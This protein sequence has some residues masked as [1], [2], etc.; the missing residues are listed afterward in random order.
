MSDSRRRLNWPPGTG[1]WER[2]V[3]IGAPLLVVALLMANSY[4]Y[5]LRVMTEKDWSGGSLATPV[6]VA[7][8][9]LYDAGAVTANSLRAATDVAPLPET[10]SL[11]A[12]QLRV[13]PGSLER[14]T[15]GLPASAKA[16]YY[17]ARLL[18][19]DGTWRRVE[20]RLRGR[21]AWHWGRDKPSLRVKL[22]KA[23]PLNWQRH[24]NFINPEDRAMVAN[25][26]DEYLAREMGLL[27]HETTFVRLFINGAYRGVYHR[28]THE[29]ESLLRLRHRLP[30]PIYEAV[31]LHTRWR[32]EDF[33]VRDEGDLAPGLDPLKQ[34]TDA[35]YL[36]PG[37]ERYAALWR[38]LSFDQYARYLAHMNLV[39]ATHADYFHNQIFYFNPAAG[40]LEPWIS[41]SNGHGMLLL[42]RGLD[43]LTATRQGDAEVPLNELMTPLVDVVLRDPRL[44]HR[45]N[46]H[47]HEALEGPG[48]AKLRRAMLRDLFQR[49]DGD[50]RADRHK[51]A[52]ERDA[53]EP[54]RLI[55]AN[56]QY[57][58][59]KR[60]LM[61]WIGLR[62]GFLRRR[63]DDARVRIWRK[64][65]GAFTV[66]VAGQAAVRFDAARLN[67]DLLAD[68]DLDGRPEAAITKPLLL[69]P[70]LVEATGPVRPSL[71]VFHRYPAHRLV[72]GPERYRFSAPGLDA[73]ALAGAFTNAVTGATVVPRVLRGAA[74]EE[75]TGASIHPWRFPHPA[76]GDLVLGPG[77]VRLD[78]TLD[79]PAG[80]R[81]I[82]R[83]GTR[84]KLGPDVSIRTRG[85]LLMDGTPEQPISVG[86][87]EPDRAWGVIAIQGPSAEG[88]R[89]RHARI[90]G[91]G[92]A[93]LGN[94]D[95]KG[96][97]SIHR[98]ATAEIADTE[99]GF[100]VGS[101]DVLN[102]VNSGFRMTDVTFRDCYADCVDLDYSDGD[103]TGITIQAAGNDGIDFMTST[104][105]LAGVSI[106]G[107]GDKGLSVGEASQV[108]AR[109]IRVAGAAIGIAI[110]DQSRLQLSGAVLEGN[111]TALD[112]FAK[113]WRYG[114]PGRLEA[115]TTRFRGN[116]VDL[117]SEEAGFVAFVGQSPPLRIVGP[118]PEQRP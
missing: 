101:D 19:P 32:A 23:S 66:E 7:V 107:A 39:S 26:L 100:N 41:D 95:Y 55:Y 64:S 22:K 38:S 33:R 104:V 3:L 46:V 50:I 88:S 30:G 65:D 24:L 51:G 4:T 62:D 15:A 67:A 1:T 86:R 118:A 40:R 5:F 61:D 77:E 72:P 113:N 18:Y 20:Y 93:R 89:I 111:E 35:M 43:R 9:T 96:M 57:A 98:V 75:A 74:P 63:L 49:L 52:L 36:P 91:G 12:V 16:R 71:W 83:A 70:G 81:L 17:R 85:P 97:V 76:S 60:R 78:S 84:L 29:D 42:P 34:M 102:I 31:S 90:R 21:G 109:D 8:A 117:R 58:G 59:A 45:R 37:P 79:V 25:P 27:T 110:K 44:R 116:E 69:H 6:A 73:G 54:Y 108:E 28:T 106:Q 10:S 13:E 47:L 53:L 48:S 99:M 14:M 82:I 112:S 87:V 68:R 56:S 94:V 114:G 80:Q 103:I 105:T 2:R 11:P 115:R 92:R